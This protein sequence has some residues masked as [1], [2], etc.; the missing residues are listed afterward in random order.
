MASID[1]GVEAASHW[2]TARK[3]LRAAAQLCAPC[4]VAVAARAE[5]VVGQDLL[6]SRHASVAELAE[7]TVLALGHHELHHPSADVSTPKAAVVALQDTYLAAR[8]AAEYLANTNSY[9][10][11]FSPSESVVF[12]ANLRLAADQ[13]ACIAAHQSPRYDGVDFAELNRIDPLMVSRLAAAHG[14]PLALL[15]E[16]PK[17]SINE[18]LKAISNALGKPNDQSLHNENV[19]PTAHRVIA[20]GK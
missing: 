18:A 11:G 5:G 1:A 12:A 19:S 8:A 16:L 4:F 17:T 3:N 6:V 7:L 14:M 9:G 2:T 10:P 13:D 20:R 15:L